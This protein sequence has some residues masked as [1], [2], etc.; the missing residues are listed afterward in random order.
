MA[1]AQTEGCEAF[2]MMLCAFLRQW[3][4]CRFSSVGS[5]QLTIFSA[6]SR[7]LCN[8]TLCFR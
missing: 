5:V 7:Y 3:K 4:M 6:V 2:F 1:V 8:K